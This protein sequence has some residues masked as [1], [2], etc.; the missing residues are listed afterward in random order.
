[1]NKG[2]DHLLELFHEL[3][4]LVFA[5]LNLAQT[6]LPDSRKLGALEQLLMDK[7]YKAYARGGVMVVLL[8][9]AHVPAFI[10]G[11]NDGGTC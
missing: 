9:L 2:G 1:M 3:G 4:G 10:F 5:T 6:F 7:V 11:L 8:L